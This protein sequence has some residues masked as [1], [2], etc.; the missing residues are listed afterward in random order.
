[1]F[2][3][4]LLISFICL[5][6]DDNTG[7]DFNGEVPEPSVLSLDI[8]SWSYAWLRWNFT[9]MPEDEF[10]SYRLYSSDSP[11]IQSDTS[12]ALMIYS[13]TSK[14]FCTHID[15][16]VVPAET[17]HYALLTTSSEGSTSWSN[18]IAVDVPDRE[19]DSV[20]A[21]VA[22]GSWPV[23]VCCTPSGDYVYV[24]CFDECEVHVIR[25]SD[26]AVTATVELEYGPVAICCLNS[27]EYVYVSHYGGVSVIRTSD[28]AVT[29]ELSMPGEKF[30]ICTLPSDEYVYVSNSYD[31]YVAVI[32]TADNTLA[33]KIYT[34]GYPRLRVRGR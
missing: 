32:R 22:V 17:S 28:N 29:A 34:N 10:G 5:S 33:G 8:T 24:C 26:N 20:A 2:I 21:V 6:C 15:S 18:E 13:I 16:L 9:S 23:E 1:M 30:G 27:G 14:Y 7:P 31:G 11:G 12:A 19:P 3:S 4:L 25:T